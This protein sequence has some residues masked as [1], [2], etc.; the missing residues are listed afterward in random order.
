MKYLLVLLLAGV[1]SSAQIKKEQLNLMPWP[2]SVVVNDGNFALNKNF[3]VN[4]TGNPNPRIFSGV[5][6]FLRRLDGRTG[7][8]FEQGFITKLNEV[9]NASLQINC[10]KSGKIGLYEDESYHLDIKQNQITI[11]ATNDLG[12]LHGLETL[13][14]MLQNNNNSFYFPSSKI[15]DFPRFTWRGLMIDVSRHFQPVD[16]IKR[17]ID[18]LA[19]MKMNVF[20]W[21]LVDDQGWR[22]E[23]KKHR[24][25]IDVASDGMYYTQEE[26]KNIVKYADERGILVVP[27]IDVPGHGSAILTAYPEIGS[28][29]I[30]LTGGTS[31]KNIQGTAIT[32]YGIERNA[33]IFSPTLDPSNPKTYQL[34]SEIFDEVCPLFPG[35]YFHI[36]GDENEGKDWDANPKIQEFMK[37][38]K[39]ANNHELQTYFTMQLVPMLKKHG[40]QLMG[41]EEILT[42]NM[43][44]DAI[45]HSWRGPNEGVIAGQSLVDAV[46]KGYKTVLSNGYYIDLMYPIASHYLNDPMPKGANLTAEEKARIL[47]G[48]ATMWTELVT[49]TTIDSRLWPRTA[50]IAERLWSAEDIT[51]VANMR[52]RL[53]VV[54]FR[55]EELGIT[56]IRNKDVILR[57]ITNDQNIASLY[58]F[59]NVCEPLKGYTRNKGGTEYQMYS[60][61]TLFADACGADAKDSLAFDDAVA[62][63]LANKTPENK[64]K[65]AAFFNKWIALNKELVALSA[66]APLVQPILPLS[67]KLTDASQ[68]LLLV[69]DNK[70]TLKADDLKSLIEQC[71]SKDHAD[72]ELS[73][74]AS[75]KKLI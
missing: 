47:G 68:E 43:S 30:T 36:G 10:T 12:V 13:L 56:H 49:P 74:Y 62:Q 4:I 39:L 33:G 2:Q 18:A 38:N 29:V 19:A 35:A 25:L 23:M 20:H 71:N 37:K 51:D 63:Y 15:S 61:F 69:L 53:D 75:L 44:K 55:L 3:K 17:N 57:N 45:I 27:E 42:K 14:Q 32:T 46:K 58:E 22:I 70:S 60:P 11:N 40:K 6:R 67:K 48:E 31:E 64:A 5:T 7:I 72:V 41:W 65:V 54:S 21:H 8:F 73:V 34:L 26:I 52:K 1:T 66:N 24:K 16:V 59:S 9:P 50:A 28:K